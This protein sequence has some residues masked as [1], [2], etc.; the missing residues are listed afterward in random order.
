MMDSIAFKTLQRP[1]SPNTYLVTPEG[2]CDEAQ[3]DEILPEMPVAP[4]ALF[5][6]VLEMIDARD[7]WT[8]ESSDEARGLIHFI[9]TSRLM[10]FKDD[11]SL[12]VLP[13]EGGARLAIY[14]RSRVGHSDLG[15][16]RKRVQ[17]M[18]RELKNKQ[19]GA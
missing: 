5:Q 16:N 8:L 9:A 11:I 12:L 17:S 19:T 15:A 4:V 1:K 14:S 7:D 6:G 3:P 10:R 2:L 18:L 13:A